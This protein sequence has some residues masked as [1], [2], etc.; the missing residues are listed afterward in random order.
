MSFEFHYYCNSYQQAV[1]KY[2]K[3]YLNIYQLSVS[4]DDVKLKHYE[5]M[6]KRLYC[7]YGVLVVNADSRIH[8]LHINT[9]DVSSI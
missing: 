7:G 1:S 4:K 9:D 3:Y 5:Y 6:K 2:M 8:L